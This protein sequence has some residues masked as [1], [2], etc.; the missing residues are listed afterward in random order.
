MTRPQIRRLFSHGV[1]FGWMPLWLGFFIYGNVSPIAAQTGIV[2]PPSRVLEGGVINSQ[3][4]PVRTMPA[5]EETA[6]PPPAAEQ[7]FVEP[8]SQ[9][10]LDSPEFLPT[11]AAFSEALD[12]LVPLVPVSPCWCDNWQDIPYVP[13]MLGDFFGVTNDSLT[14]LGNQLL[15][16]QPGAVIDPAALGSGPQS[17]FFLPAGGSSLVGRQKAANNNSPL[18]R[19][20][21]FLN[22]DYA[23]NTSLQDG[24]AD[25]HRLTPGL[26]RT[27]LGGKMSWSVRVP[28]AL[29]LDS[30]AP[31]TG[32]AGD[33]H[34]KLGNVALG[35]KGVLFSSRE[36]LVSGG[37]MLT[38]PTASDLQFFNANRR[39]LIRVQNQSVHIM[40]YLAGLWS[41]GG[42]F[43]QGFLQWDFDANGNPVQIDNGTR[44]ASA[45]TFQDANFVYLD[46]GVGYWIFKN[47]TE[48]CISGIA[49][50]M[51]LHYNRCMNNSDAVLSASGLRFGSQLNHI[52]L[53]NV[54]FG[55]TVQMG[56]GNTL[57]LGYAAPLGGGNDEQFDGQLVVQLNRF[58]GGSAN[59]WRPPAFRY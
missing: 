10:I 31:L 44:L 14:V 54:L 29:T 8:V 51:E 7:Q 28:M 41:D 15:T 59:S 40:P 9:Q 45:G 53:M 5:A 50:T 33:G 13:N 56:P 32:Q 49:P 17:R 22:Y 24:G 11:E 27:F 19:D 3:V 35:L 26:E 2:R 16:A 39:E 48:G 43:A 36:Y 12:E 1:R 25:V 30:N 34:A 55:A 52:G 21:V 23:A 6:P 37:M 47:R 38:V 58:F 42:F 57:S 46:A 4:K 18:P 20:R